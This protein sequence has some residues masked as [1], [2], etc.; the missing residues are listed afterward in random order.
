MRWAIVVA[1]LTFCLGPRSAEAA[2]VVFHRLDAKPLSARAIDAEAN[3][4]IGAAHIPG[5][6]LALIEDGRVAYTAAY[7]RR[8]VERNLPL[9][10]DTVIYGASLTK[11]AFAYLCLQLVQEGRLDLDRPIGEYLA[12]PLPDYPAYADLAADPRW[13]RITARMLLSHTSGLPNFRTVNDDRKLDIKFE[14]GSRFVYSGEGL[15]LLQFVLEAGL[16]VDVAAEMR[17]RIFGPFGMRRS[18]MVWQPQFAA[19]TAVGYDAAGKPRGH[20]RRTKAD[21]AGSLE[22]TVSDYAAFLAGVVRGQ[23]LTPKAYAEMLRPQIAIVSRHEFPSHWVDDTDANRPI[24][25]S[26]GL[27]WGLFRT[28]YG[29]AFFKEGHDDGVDHYALCVRPPR[30]CILLMTNSGLGKGVFQ[31]LADDLLGRTGLPTAWE[32]FTPYDR[33][34]DAPSQRR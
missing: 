19:G 20:E 22:T 3:R 13:R 24:Q 28:P 23:G 6:A 27:G 2:S 7:G 10:T 34:P 25:L 1:S 8:D 12:K 9:T 16:G 15:R 14:P 33:E 21:A 11:P 31:Y 29:Q 18:D 4:L 30:K 5:L 17:R 26:Y 32:G